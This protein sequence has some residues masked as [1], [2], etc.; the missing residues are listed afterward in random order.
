ML[1]T[2]SR[3]TC[4]CVFFVRPKM[5]RFF[6]PTKFCVFSFNVRCCSLTASFYMFQ[7]LKLPAICHNK[8]EHMGVR[9][10]MPLSY[11]TVLILLEIFNNKLEHLGLQNNFTFYM[12]Q[13]L[14]IPAICCNKL[15]HF[16]MPNVFIFFLLQC[17]K[18][19][20]NLF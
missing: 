12:F 18:T 16:C 10:F 19:S 2:L 13:F 6:L 8:L 1:H 14:K 15:E 5:L 3:K 9:I 7:C 20:C 11:S 4:V 17:C